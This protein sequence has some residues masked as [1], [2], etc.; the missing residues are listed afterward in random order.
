LQQRLYTVFED[1]APKVLRVLA[2]IPEG[3]GQEDAP[4]R[5]Y[6]ATGFWASADGHIVTTAQGLDETLEI[7]VQHQGRA[8]PAAWVGKD[9][10]SGIALLKVDLRA[11]DDQAQLGFIPL[12]QH[13]ALPRVATQVVAISCEMGLD[14]GLSQGLITGHN[15]HYG[16]Q[17]F[18]TTYLRADLPCEGGEVGAP[19]FDLQGRFVGVM[20]LAL[21]EIRSCFILPAQATAKIRDDLLLSGK[22]QYAYLGLKIDEESITQWRD[23]YPL[24]ISEVTEGSPA[25]RAGIQPLDVLSKIDDVKVANLQD[26]HNRM[27]Y[28]RPGQYLNLEV[29]RKG[30]TLRFAVKAEVMPQGLAAAPEAPASKP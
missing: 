10:L 7:W 16:G 13:P 2:A 27:F 3:Q 26:L 22:A 25:Q 1:N 30:Q 24:L 11:A 19:V 4:Y 17:V 21:P 23:A 6:V 15:L 12:S 5:L 29:V 14:P 20:V 18:P 8:Y 28:C 9:A